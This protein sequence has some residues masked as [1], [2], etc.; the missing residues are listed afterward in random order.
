MKQKKLL[1]EE[2][3]K[4]KTMM[5]KLNEGMYDRHGNYMG[6]NPPEWED[7]P[8][9][10]EEQLAEVE[11]F[12]KENFPNEAENLEVEFDSYIDEGTEHYV[13]IKITTKDGTNMSDDMIETMYENF[14]KV[15]GDDGYM[16]VDIFVYSED[17]F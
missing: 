12:I 13:R 11:D 2:I 8:D 6:G 9:Y 7:E 14:N 16:T 15:D 17:N 3:R 10:G 4:I 1:N 5:K